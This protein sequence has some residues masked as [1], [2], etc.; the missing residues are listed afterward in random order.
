MD[1]GRRFTP[2]VALTS[3]LPTVRPSSAR[4]IAVA[5]TF[6]LLRLPE[7]VALRVSWC[8]SGLP[9]PVS[10][11]ALHAALSIVLPSNPAL[12]SDSERSA[13]RHP[14]TLS[15]GVVS[16]SRSARSASLASIIAFS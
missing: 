6:A 5:Q 11:A 12:Y 10:P 9:R 16:A 7:L 2:G 13:Y 8:V 4:V 15:F 3:V 1:S 14:L